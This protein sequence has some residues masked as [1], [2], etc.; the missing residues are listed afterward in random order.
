MSETSTSPPVP[1][2]ALFQSMGWR[3]GIVAALTVVMFVPLIAV[4][5]VIQDRAHYQSSAVYEVSQLWGGPM[6]LSGPFLILPV[7]RERTETITNRDGVV[8]TETFVDRVEPVILMPETLDITAD[9]QTEVRRRG[10]F[11]IPVFTADLKIAFAFDPGRVDDMVRSRESVLWDKASLVFYMPRTRSF[12]GHA[13]LS[14]GNRRIDLEPGVPGANGS[15]ISAALGDPRAL[16]DLLL[17]MGLNGADRMTFAPAGRETTVSL[18]SDW[19]HPSFDGSFLPRTRSVTEAGFTATWEVPHLAR[20]IPQVSRG[21]AQLG[22]DFGVS[23]YDPVDFY[24]KVERA[25]KYGILFIALTF[26]TVLMTERLS[27]RSVHPVQF[28][29]IGVAQC[30]F[31]LL[32]LS[33]SEQV[34]FTVAYAIATAA[35]VGL[36]GIYG[37]RGL[38]LGRHARVLT[39]ALLT[40]Y[41]TLFM[42]LRSTDYALLAGSILAFAAVAVVM[43]MIRREDWFPEP[44]DS[45]PA[46]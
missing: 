24:H 35:T 46:T 30:V 14:A 33:F 20:D 34:G 18:S 40:L 4:S 26:L 44:S 8:R 36:I 13:S 42:I 23:F 31:F 1:K 15:G 10:I 37:V 38:G 11:Q 27:A 21:Q 29:L 41:G 39:G 3:F 9:S 25:A 12:S 7:E 2:R 28:L 22:S 19:P 43:V 45:V 6:T 17:E 16:S 5:F 32:L